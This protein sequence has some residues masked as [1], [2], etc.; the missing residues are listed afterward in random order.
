MSDDWKEQLL[1]LRTMS[2]RTGILHEA[3]LL[4]LKC[5]PK[6]VFDG[7]TATIK[8]DQENKTVAYSISAPKTAATAA[9]EGCAQI[10]EWVSF[11]LGPSWSMRVSI[12]S[13]AKKT[14]KY[15]FTKQVA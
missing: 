15:A 3:Q 12:T 9:K 5:Y 4:Q 6:F 13:K 11:L 7:S 2:E 1:F 14:S 8:I 10:W